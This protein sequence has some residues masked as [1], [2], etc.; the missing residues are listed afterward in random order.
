MMVFCS[1]RSLD[2]LSRSRSWY[3]DGTFKVTPPLFYQLYTIHADHYGAVLPAAYCLL[4]NKL[5]TTYCKMFEILKKAAEDRGFRL[6][7]TNWRCDFEQAVIQAVR[8]IFPQVNVQCCFF[9]FSQANWRQIS[10]SHAI[11]YRE[12]SEFALQCRMFTALAF[13]P[14]DHIP[15][16][17]MY[18]CSEASPETQSLQQYFTNT[19]IGKVVP[20]EGRSRRDAVALRRIEPIFHPDI[21]SCHSRALADEPRTTNALEGWHRRFGKII[22]KSHPHFYEFY[23]KL[24]QEEAYTEL[25]AEQLL[26]GDQNPVRA[27]K[28]Q[29][30]KNKRLHALIERYLADGEAAD[31]GH[32]LRGCAHNICFYR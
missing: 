2:L 11:L 26:A 25:L 15:A 9:H 31:V 3:G 21:W 6:A 4:P 18:L 7:L 19:Y 8:V 23:D 16:A 30:R 1:P 13:L 22:D 20:Q 27:S 5:K 12:D 17:F 10:S 28:A 32:F 14:V 29:E 24:L